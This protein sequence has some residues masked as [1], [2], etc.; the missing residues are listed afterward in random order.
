MK[1]NLIY[2][3]V[4]VFLLSTT[5][6]VIAQLPGKYKY[7]YRDSDGDGYGDPNI[8]SYSLL[9]PLGYVDN[10]DDCD[11]TNPS[12]GLGTTWYIDSDGDGFG[13]TSNFQVSCFQPLGYVDNNFDQCPGQFGT[14]LGCPTQNGGVSNNQN[15]IHTVSYQQPFSIGQ[16]SIATDDDK[17]ETVKYF[18]GLGRP[19]QE[20]AIRSGGQKQDVIK[21][22]DYDAF[23]RQ[24]KEY[25]PYAE[26]TNGGGYRANAL[27]ATNSFY[28][29][30]KYEN[31]A[32]PFSEKNFEASPLNT[33]LEQAAPGSSWVLNKSSDI[34]HTIKFDYASN[35][36]ANEVRLY[37]V[38]VNSD[39]TTILS[40]SG[41]YAVNTLSKTIT[42]NENWKPIDGYNKT[43]E[44]FKDKLG[45]IVLKR[46]YNK[47]QKYDTYY[48]YD[49]YGNLSYVL[50]PK[51]EPTQDK[52]N[53][54]ELAEL[55][56][57]YN[58]D[59]RNRVVR[60]KIPGKDWEEIVYD[61]LDRPVLTQDGKLKAQQK[62]QFTK[63]DLYGR[64][65]YTGLYTSSS[66][67]VSLQSTFDA[68]KGDATKNYEDKVSLGTGFAGTYYTNADFPTA[69]L[70]VLTVNYYDNYTFNRAGAG[71]SVNA[72][73]VIS[74]P[75]VKSLPTGTRIKVLGTSS[76]LTTVTYY[77]YKARPIYIYSK[78]DYLST[79]DIIM[80][81]LDFTGKIL[82]SSST[83][84]KSG[85][86]DIVAVDKFDY[87][88]IGRVQ[89]QVQKIN[90]HP[91]ELIA[92]NSY[93]ELG[94]LVSKGVGNI[95][96]DPV[97]RLQV[98][99]YSYTVRGW[100]KKINDVNNLSTKLFSMAIDYD[101][102]N[103]LYNG[104]ISKI[105]WRTANI[106]NSLKSYTFT[107]DDLNR[108]TKAIDNT[109][110]YNL[111]SVV[112]DKN[113]NITSLERKGH[114]VQNPNPAVASDWGTMDVLKYYY[115]PNSNKLAKVQDT[116]GK[117]FGFKDGTNT[118]NDYSYDTNGNM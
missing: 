72:Y 62:W 43:T 10:S 103:P 61:R 1:N 49:N 20:I 112:Y 56:Y 6:K 63:Y 114:L 118:G 14:N 30:S 80:N 87:D 22:V 18:D 25:L 94:R 78:N 51:S 86:A 9:P 15:Y 55:C 36:Q 19:K 82:E 11:D 59:K 8:K 71:T 115:L 109:G 100:L 75:N 93:D 54:T 13:E 48:I 108:L 40:T 89:K 26:N 81:K 17:I 53:A 4:L 27:T 64:V 46:T 60:K 5:S 44:E 105:Q 38:T 104:N 33:L 95:A 39:Y 97:N 74:T 45:R 28:N 23:G 65:I 24:S 37:N 113:G 116:S 58:Y 90:N 16:E 42:K 68:K 67:R 2:S 96:S 69:N 21:Y 102:S 34:D 52:P 84:I 70:E 107:Y 110:H 83:H 91:E 66:S 50:P 77:D 92:Q 12:I 98:V 3:I 31:T 47:G 106:D 76:W 85:K 57:Q 29:T 88:H 99:D 32:N 73:G 79:T 117:I 35:K 41:Y 111:T 101:G 7:Y